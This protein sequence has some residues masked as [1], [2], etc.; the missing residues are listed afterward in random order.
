MYV[1][2]FCHSG[3]NC[4]G[5]FCGIGWEG[6]CLAAVTLSHVYLADCLS[7][8]LLYGGNGGG[9]SGSLGWFIGSNNYCVRGSSISCVW[10][11]LLRLT[12]SVSL[13]VYYCFLSVYC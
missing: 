8:C 4:S 10:Y 6:G 13:A 1:V 11:I 9:D 3:M 5:G 12:V 7:L 2:I